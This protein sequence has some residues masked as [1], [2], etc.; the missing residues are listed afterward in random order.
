MIKMIHLQPGELFRHWQDQ[1]LIYAEITVQT[2]G[3][4]CQPGRNRTVLA[5]LLTHTKTLCF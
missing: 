5:S 1:Q 3:H 2:Q 4:E